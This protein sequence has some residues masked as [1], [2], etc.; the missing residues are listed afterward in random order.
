MLA[1]LV[2]LTSCFGEGT[3]DA[4]ERAVYLVFVSR[5]STETPR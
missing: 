1:T 3:A 5:A 2:V 4:A